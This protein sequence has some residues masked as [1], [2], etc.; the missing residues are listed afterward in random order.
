G[1]RGRRRSRGGRGRIP[2]PKVGREVVGEGAAGRAEVCRSARDDPRR[3]RRERG[4]G[5]HRCSGGVQ[6]EARRG[7][8][9][10][11]NRCPRREDQGHVPEAGLRAAGRQGADNQVRER[12]SEHDPPDRR[13]NRRREDEGRATEGRWWWRWRGWR[14][15]RRRVRLE[16]QTAKQTELLRRTDDA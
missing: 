1:G 11:R 2:G 4:D 10:V 14:R 7:W 12:G 3:A 15:R 8:E 9:V 5:P 6:G 13:R 16:P